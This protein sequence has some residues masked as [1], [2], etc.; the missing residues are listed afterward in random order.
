MSAI[1]LAPRNVNKPFRGLD[2]PSVVAEGFACASILSQTNV[3]II[4][5]RTITTNP[6]VVNKLKKGVKSPFN[7]PKTKNNKNM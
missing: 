3:D 4:D 1:E 7:F 6:S 5:T 2:P